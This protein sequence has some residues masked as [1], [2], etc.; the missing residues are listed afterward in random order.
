MCTCDGVQI[1]RYIYG[2]GVF[3]GTY[4]FGKRCWGICGKGALDSTVA[5]CSEVNTTV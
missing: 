5:N 3:V 4:N 2:N 1:M